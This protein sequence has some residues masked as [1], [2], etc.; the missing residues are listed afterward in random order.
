[1]TAERRLPRVAPNAHKYVQQVLDYGFHNTSECGIAAR[2]E[3]EFAEKLGCRY[4]VL[5]S[6]GTTTMHSALMAA[7]V[8]AG[9]EVIVPPI[10]A[11][12]TVLVALYVNAVP[13][14]ADID[15]ETLHPLSVTV[16]AET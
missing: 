12:A 11:L 9:D 10:T 8:G 7:D 1:M 13:V 4:G 6:N 5:H 16:N 3:T 2:L 15:P 14:F